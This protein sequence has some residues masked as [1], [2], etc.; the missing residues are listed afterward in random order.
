[1]EAPLKHFQRGDTKFHSKT[2]ESTYYFIL[3]IRMVIFTGHGDPAVPSLLQ[4]SKIFAL[5]LLPKSDF[6]Q[7]PQEW[8]L[9][10]TQVWAQMSPPGRDFSDHAFSSQ[11]PPLHS[12]QCSHLKSVCVLADYL[13]ILHM[14][15]MQAAP[16]CLSCSTLYLQRAA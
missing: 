12:R 5:V 3:Q 4:S 16:S 6:P 14:S 15:S 8:L 13:P 7:S 1:M 10:I 9:P 2:P 11:A